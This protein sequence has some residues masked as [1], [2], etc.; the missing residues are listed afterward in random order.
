MATNNCCFGQIVDLP[1]IDRSAIVSWFERAELQFSVRKIDDDLTKFASIVQALD[2]VCA[3][4]A[5]KY[6]VGW[7]M[8][9]KVYDLL[10]SDLI[11]MAGKSALEKFQV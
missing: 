10:K 8:Y 3:I 4:Y 5:R 9:P 11:E 6:L 2:P 7:E 1:M